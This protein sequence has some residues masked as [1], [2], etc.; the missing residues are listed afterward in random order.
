MEVKEVRAKFKVLMKFA[1]TLRGDLSTA[2]SHDNSPAQPDFLQLSRPSCYVDQ[3]ELAPSADEEKWP[4]LPPCPEP[5][6]DL[7]RDGDF[8]FKQ[9]WHSYTPTRGT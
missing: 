9:I 1:Q 7:R 5:E 8:T 3:H 4:E 2:K 6:S